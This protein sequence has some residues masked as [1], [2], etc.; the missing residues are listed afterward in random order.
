MNKNIDYCKML[1]YGSE[2]KTNVGA[3][4]QQAILCQKQYIQSN[5]SLSLKLW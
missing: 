4:Y 1:K 3:P 2:Y 5:D